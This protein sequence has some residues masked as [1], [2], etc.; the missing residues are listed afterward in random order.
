MILEYIILLVLGLG[1]RAAAGE[2]RCPA[3]AIYH[4]L[5]IPYIK[6]YMCISLLSYDATSRDLE[7][8]KQQVTS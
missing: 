8:V 6:F 2:V 4:D 5:D 1:P 7:P 3:I